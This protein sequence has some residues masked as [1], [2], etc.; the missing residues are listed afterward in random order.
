MLFRLSGDL[1]LDVQNSCLTGLLVEDLSGMSR[2][3]ITTRKCFT[4]HIHTHKEI[5]KRVHEIPCTDSIAPCDD[6][7]PFKSVEFGNAEEIEPIQHYCNDKHPPQAHTDSDTETYIGLLS[8]QHLVSNPVRNYIEWRL[9]TSEGVYLVRSHHL[10]VSGLGI[11]TPT[12]EKRPTTRTSSEKRP[13]NREWQ[14]C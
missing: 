4:S 8:A 11:A 13:L 9:E 5:C 1:W 7:R 2:S 3:E 10:F 6:R 14:N 12:L